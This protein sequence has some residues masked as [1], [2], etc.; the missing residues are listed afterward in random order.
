MKRVLPAPLLSTALFALWL[1]LNGEVSGAQVLLAAT[2]AIVIPVLCAP[3]RP[4]PVR[5]RRFG[6]ALRLI[7]TVLHDVVASNV[8]IGWRVLHARSKPPRGAFVRMSLDVHDA[9]ALATLAVITTIV[10]GTVWCELAIDRSA[11]LLHVF[12]VV[13]EAAFVAHF[14]QRYEAPL[15]EIFE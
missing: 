10:P 8:E 4:L 1:V 2:V 12:D 14:K 11:F 9:N 13:D 15:R 5:V 7:A 6:V 3:L